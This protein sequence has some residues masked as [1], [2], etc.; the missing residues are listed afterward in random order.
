MA[1]NPWGNLGLDQIGELHKAVDPLMCEQ[2][3]WRPV[4]ASVVVPEKEVFWIL[5]SRG[6]TLHAIMDD[7]GWKVR[8]M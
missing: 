6:T 5:G 1:A 3:T 8:V 4:P 7:R 2:E